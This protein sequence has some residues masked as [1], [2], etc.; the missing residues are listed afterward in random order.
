MRVE[1]KGVSEGDRYVE[2][3]QTQPFLMYRQTLGLPLLSRKLQNR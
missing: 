1:G 3:N 2:W